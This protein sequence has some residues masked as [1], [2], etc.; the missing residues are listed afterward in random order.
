MAGETTKLL[1]VTNA[2]DPTSADALLPLVYAELRRLAAHKMA[3]ERAGHTLQATALVHEAYLRLVQESNHEWRNR[4]QFM[5]VAAETM[6][7]ILVDR[8]RRRLSLKRGG[9]LEQTE[10]D[11][12]ELPGT[13]DDTVVLRVHEALE[14]LAATDPV[15]AEVVKLK[16][17]VGLSSLETATILGLNEKTVRRHWN[18][19]RA[20]LFQ[21]MSA[22]E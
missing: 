12:I 8:A 9:K 2:G 21:R 4:S 20:W 16:F 14:A 5:A 15:K 1:P 11:W 18:F 17:F 6:R 22:P 3:G 13:P 7:R 19:A 10:V